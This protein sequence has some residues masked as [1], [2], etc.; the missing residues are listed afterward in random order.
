[1][2]YQWDEEKNRANKAKHGITFEQATKAFDDPFVVSRYQGVED[3]EHRHAI[4]GLVDGIVVLFVVFTDWSIEFDE[5]VNRI[6]S[7][8]RAD[9][10]E[11]LIYEKERRSYR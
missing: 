2:L 10:S 1:M 5:P 3:G 6:I 8:R 9:R 11:R 4:L 7:A